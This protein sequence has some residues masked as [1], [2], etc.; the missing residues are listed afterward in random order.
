MCFLW[1]AWAK[2]NMSSEG[3]TL[4]QHWVST[5]PMARYLL[6]IIEIVIGGCLLIGISLRPVLF[7]AIIV[8]S[9]FSGML[10]T[11]LTREHPKPCGCMG[12]AAAA[13]EPSIIRRDL[14]LGIGR[15]GLLMGGACWIFIYASRRST[16]IKSNNVDVSRVVVAASQKS[17]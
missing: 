17:S 13:Y 4:Y 1:A 15:N 16:K 14:L 2:L 9:S 5:Y 11:E 3:P 7:F 12:A 8:L 10:I 6:P